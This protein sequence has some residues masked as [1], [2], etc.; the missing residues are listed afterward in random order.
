MPTDRYQQGLERR[1]QVLGADYVDGALAKAAGDP[2]MEELQQIVTEVGWGTF[3]TRPGL[4]LKTR[5]MLNLAM[6]TALNRPHEFE[7]HMR[8]AINNGVT[9]AEVTEILLQAAAYCGFPAAID[10][11]RI[12]KRVLDEAEAVS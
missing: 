8:G 1:R 11:F 10:S 9:K 2:M 3:W 12:A 7:I 4:A 6:L 5:S